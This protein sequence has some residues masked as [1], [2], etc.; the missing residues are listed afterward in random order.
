MKKNVLKTKKGF[1][2]I[3]SVVAIL[4]LAIGIAAVVLL[5]ARSTRDANDARDQIIAS[6][7]AQE[8]IELVRNLKDSGTL[9]SSYDESSE[10]SSGCDNLIVDYSSGIVLQNG[11]KRLRINDNGF[12]EH[13]GGSNQTKFAR[14]IILTITGDEDDD[15]STRVINVSST[16]WWDPPYA[17]P[18][19]NCTVG[20]KCIRVVSE[21][22]DI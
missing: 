19:L 14:E 2:L 13:G 12:F 9:N 4:V 20:N 22:Q 10:C 15:P 18:D 6:M 21:I 17:H 1:T 3:E 5:I 16:V 7:L 11:V 8:G